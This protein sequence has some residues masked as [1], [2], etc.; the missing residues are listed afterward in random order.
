MPQDIWRL[1]DSIDWGWRVDTGRGQFRIK[2]VN[3]SLLMIASNHSKSCQAQDKMGKKLPEEKATRKPGPR[4]CTV[5]R[6]EGSFPLGT[7]AHPAD[8]WTWSEAGP[9]PEGII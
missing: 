2:Q 9:G 7:K 4:T 8:R 3:S 1:G 6:L 5:R